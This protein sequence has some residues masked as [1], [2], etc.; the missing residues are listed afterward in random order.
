MG[1]PL[2]QETPVSSS[3]FCSARAKLDE[4]VFK[5][6][7]SKILQQVEPNTEDLWKGHGIFAV[8]GS[9]LNL[10]RQLI[11]PGYRTPSDNAHYPQGLLSCLYQLKSK[12][13][14]DFDLVSHGDERALATTHLE[15]LSENDVVVYDRGYYSYGLLLAHRKRKI[16][17]VFRLK[18][19]A[20]SVVKLF[21]ESDRTDEVIDILPSEYFMAKNH[22]KHPRLNCQSLPLRLVKY[23]KAGTTYLLGTTLM[24]QKKYGI[25]DL[26]DIYHSR[27][28]VEE[29]YKISKEL[30]T[31]EDFHGQSERGVKQEIFAHF[32][33]ITLTRLFSNRCEESFNSKS[34]ADEKLKTNFKNCLITVARNIESLFLQQAALLNKT[35]NT[36]VASISLCRQKLRPNRSYDRCSRKPI[37]KWK[38]PKRAKSVEEVV[39]S[40]I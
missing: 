27:W 36:I 38:P 8:D 14:V 17:S 39:P 16:H 35:I 40:V 31:I 4:N 25:E 28:G 32:V 11:K 30:M 19:T 13:P 29:L 5:V 15:A 33:L 10:P 37:G 21:S 34:T 24:D 18:A 7:H 3:A 6:L 2:P 12:V 23:T 26:S 20:S 22:E 9:K 1:I